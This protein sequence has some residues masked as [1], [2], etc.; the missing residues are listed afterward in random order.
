MAKDAI[1]FSYKNAT[2]VGVLHLYLYSVIGKNKSFFL[3][4][5]EHFFIRQN[6]VV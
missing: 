2:R 4:G 5:G 3:G 6:D 1:G